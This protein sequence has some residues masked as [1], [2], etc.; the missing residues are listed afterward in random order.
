MKIFHCDHCQQLVFFENVRCLSCSHALAYA[1]DVDDVLSLEAVS[2]EGQAGQE[3]QEKLWRAAK[4]GAEGKTYRLCA[5]YDRE[6]VCNW[7]IPVEDPETLCGSCRL[8]RVIPD[9]TQPGHK[10]AWYRLEVAK[11]R[12]VY[13]LLRLKLPLA[14]KTAEPERGVAFELLADGAQPVMTGHSDGVITISVAEADDAEREQRRLQLHEPYRTLLGHFRHEI[15]HYY[16]DRLL[17]GNDRLDAFRALFGDE[18]ADYAAALQ[19]HYEQ[20]APPD[21]QERFISAY[22]STHPW[23][24]WAETWAHYLHMSDTLE[25]AAACGLTLRPRRPDEPSLKTT[26]GQ[27]RPL[28]PFEQKI[29]AWF[30]LTYVLNSLNRGL[31]LADGYPFVLSTPVID[32][33]RFVHETIAGVSGA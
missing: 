4:L 27:E 10:E 19:R 26:A 11:R 33:L 14:N 30:P 22:A 3:S 23:E 2:E 1:P 17:A 9:L 20:G 7:A 18:R 29:A 31:G 6:N 13:S 5:N 12:L 15:G 25:T 16:W 24:D 32:K 8:T 21:W 28:A